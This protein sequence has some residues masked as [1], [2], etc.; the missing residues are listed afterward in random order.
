MYVSEIKRPKLNAVSR[1]T[2]WTME[3]LARSVWKMLQCLWKQFWSIRIV[4]SSGNLSFK[5][6]FV[7]GWISNNWPTEVRGMKSFYCLQEL[8]V[9]RS[10][11]KLIFRVTGRPKLKSVQFVSSC[12]DKFSLW[13]TS[14]ATTQFDELFSCKLELGCLLAPLWKLFCHQSCPIIFINDSFTSDSCCDEGKSTGLK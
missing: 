1:I 5:F 9:F 7:F 10:L 6:Y 12:D 4:E 14:I 13:M 3:L 8:R 11:L 2:W